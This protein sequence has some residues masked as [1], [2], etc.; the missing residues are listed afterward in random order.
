VLPQTRDSWVQRGL[1]PRKS[2]YSL[3]DLLELV[4]L[5]LILRHLP[6]GEASRAWKQIRPEIGGVMGA[7]AA[8]VWDGQRARVV[9]GADAIAGAVLHGR[10][11]QAL[12]IGEALADA[13]QA[14][15]G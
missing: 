2:H 8:I 12:P 4:A 14:H 13:R 6:K 15:A 9:E 5:A 10:P 7:D 11:V 1:L 3:A